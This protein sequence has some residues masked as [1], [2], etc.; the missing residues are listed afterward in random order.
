MPQLRCAESVFC[1]ARFF[2]SGIFF[3]TLLHEAILLF[4]GHYVSG[5]LYDFVT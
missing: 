1:S 4:L 2:F 5:I 3:M